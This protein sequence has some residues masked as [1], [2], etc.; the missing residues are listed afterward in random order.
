M[1][2]SQ[3]L[4]LQPAVRNLSQGNNY[5]YINLIKSTKKLVDK[6]LLAL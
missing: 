2:I 4:N 1:S 3:N 5:L 6:Y